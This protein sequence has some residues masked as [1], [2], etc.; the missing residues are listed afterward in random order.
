MENTSGFYKKIDESWFYAPRIVEAPNYILI[1]EH[2]D[3]YEY[4][5]DGWN[6]YSEE[7]IEFSQW[8]KFN[9]FD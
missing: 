9:T 3:E 7:P 6:W 2:K 8:K 1:V 4:P 5:V